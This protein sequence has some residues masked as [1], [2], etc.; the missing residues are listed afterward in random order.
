MT[1]TH[2]LFNFNPLRWLSLFCNVPLLSHTYIYLINLL[3]RNYAHVQRIIIGILVFWKPRNKNIIHG[4]QLEELKNRDLLSLLK[5]FCYIVIIL[6][7][8]LSRPHIF[9]HKKPCYPWPIR[10][11]FLYLKCQDWSMYS[12]TRKDSVIGWKR[13]NFSRKRAI[14]HISVPGSGRMLSCRIMYISYV[15]CVISPRS[16]L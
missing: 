1:T 7:R 4:S 10:K 11:S 5:F 8:K 3:K 16:L 9:C 6:L 2:L 13:I 12:S 14:C 15:T